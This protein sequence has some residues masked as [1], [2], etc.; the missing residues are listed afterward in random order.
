MPKIFLSYR[1]QDSPAHAG[2]LYDR[3]IDEFG[4]DQVFM[5]IDA[6]EL[7][8]DFVN[9]INESVGACDV[10]LALIGPD[11]L[12]SVAPDERPRLHDSNDFV[13][14]EIA[15]ALK[16]DVRVIPLLVD[17]AKMPAATELPRDLKPLVRRH[18]LELDD[19]RWRHDAG[20]LVS[21]L[22]QLDAGPEVGTAPTPTPPPEALAPNHGRTR[23]V[24]GA[25]AAAAVAA[26][27]IGAVVVAGGGDDDMPPQTAEAGTQAAEPSGKP[28]QMRTVQLRDG[29]FTANMPTG[30]AL[31]TNQAEAGPFTA[32]FS[33]GDKQLTIAKVVE[34]PAANPTG[35]ITRSRDLIFNPTFTDASQHRFEWEGGKCQFSK[36]V[37]FV[38][39]SADGDGYRV[40]GSLEDEYVA[41][42]AG[43]IRD[44]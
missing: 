25:F 29:G 15:T 4:S 16:R 2:R 11:W 39:R 40:T 24:R 28:L 30:Y 41:A 6:I 21:T 44:Q 8:V 38:G 3:L 17:G 13:R 33:A 10:L 22:K 14:L 12:A 27:A 26:L 37:S 1:R 9:R 19:A 5:D 32:V 31:D 7:G 42:V 43:S 23:F 35:P 18:A 34:S 20:V 36:C